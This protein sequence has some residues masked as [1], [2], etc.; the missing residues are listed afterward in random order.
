MTLEISYT[1]ES[2]ETLSIIYN[3]IQGRFG[4]RSA[5]KFLEQVD[6]I[7]VL[8]STQP[9]MFKASTVDESVR[10]G[11]ITKQCSVFYRV[12]ENSIELLF[13]WDNRQ[14]PLFG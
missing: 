8:I 14:E 13:F 2:K 11:L 6:K 12:R 9:Y 3:F 5:N 7:V 1:P 4:E 10:I